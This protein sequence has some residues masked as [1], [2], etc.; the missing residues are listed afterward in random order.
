MVAACG[1]NL[2]GKGAKRLGDTRLVILYHSS[3][4]DLLTLYPH[5]MGLAQWV[6]GSP[7][8]GVRFL[9]VLIGHFF[10]WL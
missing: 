3:G 4:K 1:G 9:L 10:G 6:G 5:H 8:G 2:T 7:E